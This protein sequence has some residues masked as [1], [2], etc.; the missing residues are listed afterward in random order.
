MKGILLTI[1][2][3]V[4]LI[5][6][7]YSGNVDTTT[8]RMIAR[9]FYLSRISLS[10]Q[11]HLKSLSV[12]DVKLHLIHQEFNASDNPDGLKSTSSLP[13]YYVF[14]AAND[15]GFIIVSADDR[16][17]PVLGLFLSWQVLYRQPATGIS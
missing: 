9:N 8:A 1:V 11:T 4:L 15:K 3:N 16:V 5:N 6:T 17:Y 12:Q 14:N 13:L 7:L 2:W 10:N